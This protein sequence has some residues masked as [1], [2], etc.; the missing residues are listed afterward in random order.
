MLA[1]VD[2]RGTVANAAMATVPDGVPLLWTDDD[3]NRRLTREK[4][5]KE[6]LASRGDTLRICPRK[7]HGLTPAHVSEIR[8]WIA[9]HTSR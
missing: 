5:V 1:A 2:P 4:V 8:E 3:L 6:W 7:E 9:A